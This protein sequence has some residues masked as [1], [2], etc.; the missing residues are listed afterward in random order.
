MHDF[1]DFIVVKIETEMPNDVRNKPP[2]KRKGWIKG[3]VN[4]KSDS[5]DVSKHNCLIIY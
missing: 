5:L 3:T 2:V 1:A 4:V